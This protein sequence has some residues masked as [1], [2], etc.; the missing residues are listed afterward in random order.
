MPT[1][2]HITAA[3]LVAT[4]TESSWSQAYNAGKLYAVLSLQKDPG[5]NEHTL[6]ATIGKKIVEVLEQEY[7]TLEEKNLNSIKQAVAATYTHIP[8]GIQACL[9]VASLVDDLL[10]VYSFGGGKVLIK[11]AGKTA[12]VLD[13][14]EHA[15]ADELVADKRS[16]VKSASGKLKNGDLIVLETKQLSKLMHEQLL[17]S[18]A[19]TPADIVETFSPKVHG[20]EEGGASASILL[21][22]EAE[23]PLVGAFPED[24]SEKEDPEEKPIAHTPLSAIPPTH[25]AT[26]S[27]FSRIKQVFSSFPHVSRISHTKKL[28]LTLAVILV[29]VFITSVYF[30]RQKQQTT[31]TTSLFQD[32]YPKAQKKY[33]EGE[34]LVSLNRG[35]AHDAFVSAQQILERNKDKFPKGSLEEKQIQELLTK[36]NSALGTGGTPQASVASANPSDTPLLTA[37][38]KKTD[39]RALATDGEKSYIASST[40]IYSVDVSGKTTEVI[41]NKSDWKT[42]A[43]LGTYG[44]NIYVLDTSANQI[45][46]F[47]GGS[48][49]SK[50]N[51]L[52]SSED[53]SKA[54]SLTND[55]S[56]YV[57][58]SDGTMKKYTRGKP[59]TFTV[60]N[61]PTPLKN[62]TQV[63]TT[64]DFDHLYILDKG[65]GQVVVLTKTG[66]FVTAYSAAVLKQA[67]AI[68]VS[69]K[70]KKIYILSGDKLS[71][72]DLH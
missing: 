37:L 62:P 51:Y 63:F 47:A 18:D 4:P 56:M 57:L 50:A 60:N 41:T 15:I 16:A 8:E 20:G 64:T 46:K 2:K 12:V 31:K 49:G 34:A 65:T 58:F 28:F 24:T 1:Q 13:S 5:T 55:T 17:E 10:Y 61:L 22:Q 68:D 66:T 26:P 23:D 9:V 54:I 39:A 44:G 59:D 42:L 67:K 6:L 38:Q 45:I 29:I 3:T 11:R 71:Q 36:V 27:L 35:L 53:F 72:L 32:V 52:T 30:A 33:E 21:Y 70:N 69:E 7:F 40:T 43:G 48:A 14:P 19:Q 25:H